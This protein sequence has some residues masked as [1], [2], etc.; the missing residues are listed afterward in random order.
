MNKLRTMA[1]TLGV[2]GLAVLGLACSSSETP[3]KTDADAPRATASTNIS[4]PQIAA[5]TDGQQSV[6]SAS[7][8]MASMIDLIRFGGITYLT[9]RIEKE[10]PLQEENLGL[11]FGQVAFKRNVEQV[12]FK[13]EGN[14][15]DPSGPQDGDAAFL[16]V[17]TPVYTVKGYK[18]EFMLAARRND[19]L[20][21]YL[22]DTNPSAETGSDL[23][24]LEGKVKYIGVN[25]EYD[26]KTELAA[27]KDQSQ[28]DSL[29]RM[30]LDAP[31]DQNIRDVNQDNGREDSQRDDDQRP[32]FTPTITIPV[33]VP[34]GTSTSQGS[35]D[36][37][38][39]LYFLA[40]HLKDGITVTRAYRLQPNL[41]ISVPWGIKLP[42]EFR[43]AIE[44]ALR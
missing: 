41:L 33:A 35:H 31:I 40:F 32:D 20:V 43:T 21:L 25:S 4:P 9:L 8:S 29:V 14:V 6:V 42:R 27:I 3:V 38:L 18:P 16:E 11:E 22:S 12:A 44:D 13:Y 39:D 36:F 19:E 37:D 10:P 28:V 30:V 26:G 34:L 24:D 2:L 1:I 23:M 17:G 7:P 5:P 15:S